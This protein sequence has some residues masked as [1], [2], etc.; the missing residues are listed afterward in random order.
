MADTKHPEGQWQIPSF[1]G[2]RESALTTIEQNK[3]IP[4]AW[5]TLL[6]YEIDAYPATVSAVRMD[7][8]CHFSGGKKVLH[9][10]I[11]PIF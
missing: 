3:D 6:K 2:M 7:A 4:P 5:K 10:S 9:A 1:K 11:E 8:H